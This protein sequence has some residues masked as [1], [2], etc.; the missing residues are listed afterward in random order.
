MLFYII[1]KGFVEAAG[2]LV[3]RVVV[4]VPAL[5]TEEP[6][7]LAENGASCGKR[8]DVPP[9][10]TTAGLAEPVVAVVVAAINGWMGAI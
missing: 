2:V 3:G 7:E 9:T 1:R 8:F 4:V 5:G 6:N 10:A